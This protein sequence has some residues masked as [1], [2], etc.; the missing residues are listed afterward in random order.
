[1]Y[2]YRCIITFQVVHVKEFYYVVKNC[3]TQ[4]TLLEL[5]KKSL[6]TTT[7]LTV[8]KLKTRPS[9]F[10]GGGG[11]GLASWDFINYGPIPR[12]NWIGN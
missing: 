4:L 9:Y 7:Y 6:I 5:K 12:I 8:M 3:V 10:P 1:M 11:G 2:S